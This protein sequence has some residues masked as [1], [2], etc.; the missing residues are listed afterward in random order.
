MALREVLAKFGFDVDSK[1][2]DDAKKK[3]GDY[4]DKLT[5][6]NCSVGN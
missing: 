4:A 6:R 5:R 2:L 1:K 3:T